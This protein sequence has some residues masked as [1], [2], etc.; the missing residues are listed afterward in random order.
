MQLVWRG[1]ENISPEYSKKV[2]KG[3]INLFPGTAGASVSLGFAGEMFQGFPGDLDSGSRGSSSP[4]IESQYL[5]SVDSFG[6][7]PTTSAPQECVSA[8]GGA[9]GV[10]GGVCSSGEGGEMPGSFVP[11]VTAITTSQ[12]LQWMV[13]PTLSSAGQS[14]PGTS[15]MAQPAPLDTYELPG[16]SYGS[17]MGFT[18]PGTGTDAP[19]PVRQSRTRSRRTRDETLTP[20]EEEKRRVRRE[21]NKLA[22]AKCRNR[23]RDLTD[24]LQSETDIL[25][26]E[27]AELEAE[28]S[29]LQ[30]EKERL[31][32]VLVAHQPGC[33]IPYHEE[34]A[35]AQLQLQLQP[36][37][38]VVGLTVK[39]DTFYL[40][41]AY[42]AHPS[43]QPPPPPPPPPSA[44]PQPGMMQEREPV[45]STHTSGT[46]AVISL[47]TP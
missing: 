4:S 46:A 14:E 13:Q 29:E 21:R 19:G 47:L 31:E 44:P 26:E 43:V 36:A 42:T 2:N 11:T 20:E 39:E 35:S 40:P 18:P 8:S 7:P 38:S 30:K 23:R 24:R 16:P 22:A 37:V 6:S 3:D 15:A 9:G 27:K 33:K 25:E 28:I 5:S 10:G 17:G 45:G 32:F 41:P 12:D 1:T 34:Q